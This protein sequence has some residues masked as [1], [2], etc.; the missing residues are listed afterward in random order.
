MRTI[1]YIDGF[2]LY[3]GSLKKTPYKWLDIF[4]LANLLGKEQNPKADII[5]IK[6]FTADIK[7]KL[8]ERGVKSCEAQ[9]DYLLSLKSHTP[10]IQI[11]KG[12]Y[13]ITEGSYHPYSEPVIFDK[14]VAVW[15][16]EE[17][18]TD[19]NIALHMLCDATDKLCDQIILFSNDSD[20]SPAIR[21]IKERH[22]EIKIGVITPVNDGDQKMNPYLKKDSDWLRH[23]IRTHELEQCQLPDKVIT[24]KRKIIKPK[25][26]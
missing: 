1:V 17:K 14:K 24:R 16:A 11:I 23:G 15:K 7:A 5:Q 18:L 8:S 6:Y 10:I 20:L 9:Q 22:P 19:V 25:H 4:A 13:S 2:N 21:I 3:F 12:R 26:W